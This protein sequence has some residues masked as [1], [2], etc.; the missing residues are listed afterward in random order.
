MT[1][2]IYFDHNAPRVVAAGLRARDVDVLTAL[3]DGADRLRDEPLL[4]RASALGRLLFSRDDD[5]LRIARRWLRERREFGGL[6]YAHQR[7]SDYGRLIADL[8]LIARAH[9]PHEV[10]NQIFYIPL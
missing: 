2:P 7:H 3:E 10:V 5:L 6:A 8:E 4:E 9:E 1:V